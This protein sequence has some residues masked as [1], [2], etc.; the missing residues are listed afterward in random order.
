MINYVLALCKL[1]TEGIGSVNSSRLSSA[2]ITHFAWQNSAYTI[3]VKIGL[4]Y[5]AEAYDHDDSFIK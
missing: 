4:L 5:E 3:M 1:G 2:Y